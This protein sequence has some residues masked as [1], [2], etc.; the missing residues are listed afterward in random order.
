M[1]DIGEVWKIFEKLEKLESLEDR[2]LVRFRNSYLLSETD[3]CWLWIKATDDNGY[4]IFTLNGK[5]IKAHVF[6]FRYFKIKYPENDLELDHLCR[7]RNCVNP[8]HLEPV[9][10]KENCI[11][12]IGAGN[13]IARIIKAINIVNGT[14]KLTEEQKQLAIDLVENDAKEFRRSI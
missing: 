10:H 2:D 4:G 7:I 6:S 8:D 11:R 3:S 12:G 5:S 13:K 1:S 14:N 9:T